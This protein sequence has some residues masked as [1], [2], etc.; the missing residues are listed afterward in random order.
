MWHILDNESKI[1]ADI[2][3]TLLEGQG[4]EMYNTHIDIV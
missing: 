1:D 3:S 2:T 4:T